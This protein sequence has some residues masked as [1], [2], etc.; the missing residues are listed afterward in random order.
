APCSSCGG[1]ISKSS[2]A[3]QALDFGMAMTQGIP[4]PFW[5][6]AAVG[7]VVRTAPARSEVP[8]WAAI[9]QFIQRTIA[10]NLAVSR[11]IS[12]VAGL[13]A[14]AWEAEGGLD[15]TG[16]PPRLNQDIEEP[17]WVKNLLLISIP[18]WPDRAIHR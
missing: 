10:L 15:D 17:D 6:A 5:R 13:T 18:D 2:P 1:N 3:Y 7:Q 9:E 16:H 4:D 14:S 11:G 12:A 8:E